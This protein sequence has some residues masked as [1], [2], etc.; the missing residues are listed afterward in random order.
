MNNPTNI[1]QYFKYPDFEEASKIGVA[2]SRSPS[3]PFTNIA[4]RPIDYYPFDPAYHDV[5]LIMSPPYLTPPSSHEEGLTAPLGTY[6]PSIDPN[7]FFDDDGSVWLYFS[8]N[9]YRNWVWDSSPS[10]N[11]YIEESNIYVVRL[12]TEWWSDPHAQTLPGVH[13]SFRDVYKGQPANWSTSVNSSFPG[14]ERKDGWVAVIS[15][16]LQPQV[17]LL[18]PERLSQT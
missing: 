10:I 16:A 1:S 15:N 12:S 8:R 5:N 14:P 17:G 18:F 9:A 3:G 4:P 2:V 7:V 11:K 6:I 13:P